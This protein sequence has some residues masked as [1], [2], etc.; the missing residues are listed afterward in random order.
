MRKILAA[1]AS[2]ALLMTGCGGS[3]GH[4][5]ERSYLR[6]LY[7]DGSD[8]TTLT[9]SFFAEEDAPIT[10]SAKD[11]DSARKLAELK[12]GKKIFTGFTEL[13]VLGNCR[14]RDTLDFLLNEWKISPSCLVAHS[15][16]GEELL[17][18]IPPDKLVGFVKRAVEQK[19]V[20]ECDIVTV[21]GD[22]LSGDASAETAEITAGGVVG[23]HRIVY[24]K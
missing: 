17:E 18:D 3:S 12:T 4:V 11:T 7:I 10:V 20:S 8:D 19:I 16:N 23:S 1:F 13:I 5:Y 14:D 22:L 15:S 21:L 9:L 6:T 24:T 2:A